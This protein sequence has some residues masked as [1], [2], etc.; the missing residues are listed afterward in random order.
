MCATQITAAANLS[1]A[2]Q[3]RCRR[4]GATVRVLRGSSSSSG[5][6]GGDAIGKAEMTCSCAGTAQEPLLLVQIGNCR[7]QSRWAIGTDA[8]VAV[9]VTGVVAIDV[10]DDK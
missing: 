5:G 4:S 6:E 7:R 1:K 8:S 9:E 3:R 10:H 2:G